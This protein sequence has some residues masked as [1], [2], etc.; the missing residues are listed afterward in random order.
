MHP[1][2]ILRFILPYQVLSKAV[3]FQPNG[4]VIIKVKIKQGDVV[5][6]S[7]ICQ[8]NR[9]LSELEHNVAMETEEDLWRFERASLFNLIDHILDLNIS[10][11]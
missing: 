2:E 6:V 11:L 7:I 5:S 9:F 1:A 4:W 10:V 3:F 8:R